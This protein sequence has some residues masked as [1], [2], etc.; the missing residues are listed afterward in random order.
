MIHLRSSMLY[1]T[2]VEQI[3]KS[4]C[5]HVKIRFSRAWELRGSVSGLQLAGHYPVPVTEEN[6]IEHVYPDRMS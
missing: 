2:L 3:I 4:K 5:E 1:D 6:I